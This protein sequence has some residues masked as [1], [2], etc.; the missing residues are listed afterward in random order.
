MAQE[1]MRLFNTLAIALCDDKTLT[2]IKLKERGIPMPDT[3]SADDL[4]GRLWKHE[5]ADIAL[6][7]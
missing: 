7:N 4:P 3:S 6:K 5:L 1:G 2:Y